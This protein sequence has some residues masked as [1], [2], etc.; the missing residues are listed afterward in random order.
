VTAVDQKEV[1]R[2]AYQTKGDSVIIFV[3]YPNSSV[4]AKEIP[5]E[6]I[7]MQ[8]TAKQEIN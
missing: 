8:V 5:S 4:R 7:E 1:G 6:L 2:C 3:H